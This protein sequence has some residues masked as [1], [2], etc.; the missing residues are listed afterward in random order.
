MESKIDEQQELLLRGGQLLPIAP[1]GAAE[2]TG[3]GDDSRPVLLSESSKSARQPVGA[4]LFDGSSRT[5]QFNP[6]IDNLYVVWDKPGF[7]SVP[8]SRPTVHAYLRDREISAVPGRVTLNNCTN[9]A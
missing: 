2:Y 6:L 7:L 9:S 8:Q 4:L 1:T 3:D 5:Q